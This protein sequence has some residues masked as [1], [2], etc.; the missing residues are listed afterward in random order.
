MAGLLFYRSQNEQ[1]QPRIDSLGQGINAY[2]FSTPQAAL[3]SSYQMQMNGDIRALMEY[4][5]LLHQREWE[6][7]LKT[8]ELHDFA[9][10][11]G[12][13]ILF[14]TQNENGIKKHRYRWMEKDAMSGLWHASE[15]LIQATGN[16]TPDDP[17]F[18]RI[19]QW[20]EKNQSRP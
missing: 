15:Q 2:D 18:R 17:V 19:R 6:E 11:Q 20:D 12:K 4:D 7:E 8:L 1:A 10:Y 9:E 13:M 5:R 14:Y 16:K 3:S